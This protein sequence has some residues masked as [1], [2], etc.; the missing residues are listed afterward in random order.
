MWGND[1][2]QVS[3]R[4]GEQI[5]GKTFRDFIPVIN[6][7][8][9]NWVESISGGVA[10]GDVDATW[11]GTFSSH[12]MDFCYLFKVIMKW[13]WCDFCQCVIDK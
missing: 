7:L 6:T 3:A 9:G 8:P 4:Y 1:C 5:Q 10:R 12:G 11:W 2:F 13:K